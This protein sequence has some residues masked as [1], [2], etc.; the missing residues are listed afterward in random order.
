M[1]RRCFYGPELTRMRAMLTAGATVAEVAAALERSYSAV[2]AKA[3]VRGYPM[4][5][6]GRPGR[7]EREVRV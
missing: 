5:G 2:Y 6:P 7:R 1:K 3:K 4:R